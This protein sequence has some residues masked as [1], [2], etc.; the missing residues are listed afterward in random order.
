M[1]DTALRTPLYD[2][3]VALGG[4]VVEFAGWAL[5]VQYDGVI[6]EHLRCRKHA[7]LFDVSHMGRLRLSGRDAQATLE[8]AFT[9]DL[10]RLAAGRCRYGLFCNA[11]G[12][13][14]DDVIICRDA[15]DT[16]LVIVNAINR[17]TDLAW[18]ESLAG[19]DTTI[20]DET[21]DGALLALQGPAAEQVLTRL[22]PATTQADFA[23]LRPFAT[24]PAS[25]LGAEVTISRT[26]YTGGP[27]Y[28][29]FVPASAAVAVWTGL[30]A[31]GEALG[32]GP[33]GLGARDT[34]RLEAGFCLWGQDIGP[35]RDPLT[36]G[37]GR[38]VKLDAPHDFVGKDALRAVAA[39][40]PQQQLVGLT[41]EGR[42]VVRA[43]AAVVA[44]EQT[45]GTVTSGTFSPSLETSIALAYVP[46]A[47]TTVGD[48][49]E[50]R[51]G[52]RALPVTITELPFYRA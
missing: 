47:R 21:L 51:V 22:L 43:G 4:R 17:T 8:R 1:T 44:D 28:E 48:R 24:L 49:Y 26:G 23:T 13:V 3:H 19:D 11:D 7:A 52:R 36:A 37:L 38:Y 27:G 14:I 50:V 15:D 33:A 40:G 46:P 34:L 20:V 30:L 16:W 10:A 5:P 9:N 2:Q 42:G 25:L 45:I 18:L 6:A 41:V 35:D 39:A 29:L 32:V 12:G 31:A